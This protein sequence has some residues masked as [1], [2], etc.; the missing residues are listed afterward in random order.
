DTAFGRDIGVADRHFALHIDRAAHRIDDAGKFDEQPVARGLDDAA[1]MF[2]DLGVAELA[3][4][5][6]ERGEGAFLVPTHEPGV[7]GHV[8]GPRPRGL[9]PGARPAARS[10]PTGSSTEIAIVRVSDVQSIRDPLAGAQHGLDAS[11]REI[12]TPWAA[13]PYRLAKVRN[14]SPSGLPAQVP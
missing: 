10:S 12:S 9:P 13:G 14:P 7:T 6:P 11:I 2:L 8:H 4:D 3:A 5:R 1:A